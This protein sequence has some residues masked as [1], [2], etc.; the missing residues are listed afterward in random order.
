M[1]KTTKETKKEEIENLKNFDVKAKFIRE[2]NGNF[3]YGTIFEKFIYFSC[4]GNPKDTDKV[5]LDGLEK[6]IRRM[7]EEDQ[8]LKDISVSMDSILK[9][10]Q[11]SKTV[12]SCEKKLTE[13]VI[14]E[15]WSDLIYWFTQ[16]DGEPTLN[17][18]DVLN[19]ISSW[20]DLYGCKIYYE[21]D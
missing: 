9:I 12:E 16:R 4:E 7:I 21:I 19:D 20:K 17:L 1:K 18:N 3:G 8:D 15:N 14:R 2:K 10:V 13:Q 11:E 6:E 5:I